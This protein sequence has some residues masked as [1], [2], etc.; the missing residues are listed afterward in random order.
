MLQRSWKILY[1]CLGITTTILAVI[2]MVLPILPTTPFLL[3][4]AYFFSKSSERLH[5]WLLQHKIFG[6]II[7]DW[8]NYG[9]VR[10][11]A[12]IISTIMIVGLFSYTLI[13]VQ[14]EMWIKYL[15]ALSGLGVL[16]FL[17]T[18]PSQPVT[19]NSLKD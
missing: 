6:P 16:T 15:V 12:K 8:E 1:L 10:V 19:K 5:T 14:V 17:L 11:K 18:R 9:V 7:T 3:L 2:G 13:F 4:S